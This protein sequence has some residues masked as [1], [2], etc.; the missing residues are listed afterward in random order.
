MWRAKSV[1][2]LSEELRTTWKEDY[3]VLNSLYFIHTEIYTRKRARAKFV[4]N[5][6][7]TNQKRERL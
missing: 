1:E 6:L 7:A 3:S 5:S 4:R 2:K